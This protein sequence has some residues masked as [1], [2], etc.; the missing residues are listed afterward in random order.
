VR[1]RADL[2]ARRRRLQHPRRQAGER[3]VGLMHN[4]V[5]NPAALKAP[6]DLH[7]FAAARMKPI[8]NP[9]LGRVF[10]GSMSGD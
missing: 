4:D 1:L 8:G 10:V 7:R 3:A 6:S 9:A 5:R 2:E